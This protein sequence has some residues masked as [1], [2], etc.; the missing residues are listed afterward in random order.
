MSSSPFDFIDEATDST[1]GLE[2][3]ELA[4]NIFTVLMLVATVVMA[5]IFLG[6]FVNPQSGFN[7]FPPP[8]M[9]VLVLPA[10]FT[11]TPQNV[12]PSTWTP[13]PSGTPLPT[14]TPLPTGT[15]TPT[16][17]PSPP[18]ATTEPSPTIA[19][20]EQS[21]QVQEGSPAYINNFAHADAGCQWL[22]V[23]GL[24][25][26]I[27]GEPITD[28]SVVIEVGGVLDGEEISYLTLSGLAS[29]APYGEGGYEI[30]LGDTPIASSESLWIQ[31]KTPSAELALSEKIYFDTFEDCQKN[32][33]LI[34]FVQVE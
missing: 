12:L 26:D 6:I 2:T 15:P 16:E 21:F 34:T 8:T 31:L 29:G 19:E 18:T 3:T 27:N 7:P 28:S 1:K 17:T 25:F 13:L 11:P 9:P 24:L 22:G 20:A 30:V 4:W 33:V 5:F 23:A 32:L 14:N 10:T